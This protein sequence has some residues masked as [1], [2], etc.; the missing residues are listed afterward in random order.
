MALLEEAMRVLAVPTEAFMEALKL[1]AVREIRTWLHVSEVPM[2][3]RCI[4]AKRAHALLHVLS[5]RGFSKCMRP[6]SAYALMISAF[7]LSKARTRS[8]CAKRRERPHSLWAYAH[9]KLSVWFQGAH[10]LRAPMPSVGVRKKTE[11]PW[12]EQEQK[13]MGAY[14][15][16]GCTHFESRKTERVHKRVR[17]FCA[18]V[19]NF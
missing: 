16:D 3:E 15:L 4:C 1:D 2:P 19:S 18:Y 6:S 5:L 9:K 10:A 11:P 8:M 7:A 17:T 14:A 13:Y 12:K